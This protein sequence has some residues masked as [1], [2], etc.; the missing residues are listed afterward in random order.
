MKTLYPFISTQG[1]TGAASIVAARVLT[2]AGATLGA[3]VF[4]RARVC[5]SGGFA[6][7]TNATIAAKNGCSIVETH[8]SGKDLTFKS[9]IAAFALATLTIA[10]VVINGETV[11]LGTRVYEF[12]THGTRTLTGS[13]VRADISAAASV[14][15]AQG[16]LTLPT[17][18]VAGDSMQIGDQ[19][20]VFV[21]SGAG[22][23]A[24]E[25]SIGANV[26]A[27]KINI[28]AAINGTDGFNTANAK[29]SASAFSGDVCTLTA[30]YGGAVG[31]SVVTTQ[32]ITPA[33]GVFNAATLGTTT[34]GVNCSAA[35]AVTALALAITNDGSAICSAAD[36][37]GDTV[38]CT[39]SV[40][41]AAAN[42]YPS[43]ET[44]A[45]GS[46]AAAVFAGG[47]GEINGQ[48]D[49]ELTNATAEEVTLRFGPPLL[50]PESD[51][52]FSSTLNVTHAA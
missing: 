22:D 38:V 39:A 23:S 34:A 43:I 25:I 49:I 1:T 13:R 16:T 40:A 30:R 5:N 46:F 28:V 10:G 45:N 4:L 41:G 44:M 11:T 33:D 36:G 3:P 8:T 50:S 32:L 19:T 48:I 21:A 52:D 18:P 47:A 24:G 35:H 26:A 29:V 31:N 15:K 37:T 14:V 20:Y 12:D 42:E 17:I 51:T 7:A 6:N 2:A 9:S 27:S